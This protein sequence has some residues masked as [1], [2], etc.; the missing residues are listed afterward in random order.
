MDLQKEIIENK[1]EFYNLA[2]EYYNNIDKKHRKECL[3]TPKSISILIDHQ[4]ITTPCVE[5]KLELIDQ[6]YQKNIGHYFLYIDERK[7][8]VDEFLV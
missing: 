4:F 8:F 6:D 3:I 2:I 7:D 5:I 1:E